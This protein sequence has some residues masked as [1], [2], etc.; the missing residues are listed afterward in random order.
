MECQAP[1][2]VSSLVKTSSISSMS[3]SNLYAPPVS[4]LVRSRPPPSPPRPCS[5]LISPA[6]A[7]WAAQCNHPYSYAPCAGPRFRKYRRTRSLTECPQPTPTPRNRPPAHRRRC[8]I[9]GV[10]R[11]AK[12][13]CLF[14]PLRPLLGFLAPPPTP[15][16]LTAQRDTATSPMCWQISIN[17]LLTQW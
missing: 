2:S 6:P 14:P 8:Q 12:R 1:I 5:S 3:I 15:P 7:M 4:I 16:N 10:R 17:T 13:R 11:G 9:S